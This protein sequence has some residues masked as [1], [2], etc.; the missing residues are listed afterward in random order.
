MGAIKTLAGLVLI[1]TAGMAQA[2]PVF[3]GRLADG[4]P[5]STCTV[6]GDAKCAMFYYSTLGITILNNW[7]IGSGFFRMDAY[8]GSAQYFAESLN[9]TSGF[10]GWR[11]PTGD[12]NAAAGNSNEYKAIFEAAGGFPEGLS[13]QFDGVQG[14]YWAASPSPSGPTDAW[15][16][17]TGSGEQIL[18]YSGTRFNAAA[19]RSGDVA[20]S[21][22]EVGLV[23]EPASLA[24]VGSSLLVMVTIR[25]RPR[26]FA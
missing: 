18:Y 8:I 25:R 22:P 5:S 14:V 1:A 10:T 17:Y 19:V 12:G 23:S 7:S 6:S 4:T 2:S 16:F 3:H 13:Q 20:P 26:Q 15:A 9:V 24:L 11:L 21:Q